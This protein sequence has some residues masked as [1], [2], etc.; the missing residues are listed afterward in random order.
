MRYPVA[1]SRRAVSRSGPT[2]VLV[3]QAEFH[4][5][6]FD[7]AFA[8]GR[9]AVADGLAQ[10]RADGELGQVAEDALAAVA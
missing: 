7:G 4:D 8:L 2:G 5:E 9:V 3:E 6:G 10:L 1:Y